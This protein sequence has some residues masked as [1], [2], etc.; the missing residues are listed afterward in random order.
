MD[1][2]IAGIPFQPGH[3]KFGGRGR[4]SLNKSTQAKA[5]ALMAAAL[6]PEHAVVSAG[7]R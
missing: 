6:T 1:R 2:E 5:Q 3:G 4:G 7:S